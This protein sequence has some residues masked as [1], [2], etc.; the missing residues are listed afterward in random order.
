MIVL[1]SRQ[2]RAQQEERVMKGVLRGRDGGKGGGS[3]RRRGS[4]RKFVIEEILRD[5]WIGGGK[6]ER[7]PAL[8]IEGVDV[9]KMDLDKQTH[10]RKVSG[11]NGY[12]ERCVAELVGAVDGNSGL[13]KDVDEGRIVDD[14]GLNEHIEAVWRDGLERG[15]ALEELD[16]GLDVFGDGGEKERTESIKVCVNVDAFIIEKQVG[17]GFMLGLDL[18][19]LEK[20]SVAT[21]LSKVDL[22]VFPL[23]KETDGV[24][25]CET[26]RGKECVDTS[27]IDEIDLCLWQ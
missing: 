3:G 13:D 22:D 2:R 24:D 16:D 20:R 6:H 26:N 12:H 9:G 25:V 14:D 27:L 11:T 10:N 5:L 17:D 7:G 21:G 18:E 23:E 8:M 19:T 15:A 1:I 4:E